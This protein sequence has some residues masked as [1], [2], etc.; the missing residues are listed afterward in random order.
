MT[1]VGPSTRLFFL[2]GAL[3]AW[4]A[5]S[6]AQS[7]IAGQVRD[8]TGAVLPGVTVEAASPALI[9]GRRGVATDGQGRYS[10]VDVR[11]G[12]YTVTFTLAGFGTVIRQGI[13]LPSNFTATVDATLNVGALEESVTVTGDAPLV[14]VQQTTRTQVLNRE[15]LDNL[16]TSR[17]T[18]TQAMLLAGVQMTGTDVGGSRA[19][20][21]LLLE[22]HGASS[23]HSTYNIDGMQV[24]TM[25]SD[26]REQNYYQDQSNQEVSIQTSGGNA[27][28]AKGGVFLNMIPKDGGNE[29]HGTSVHRRV[30][31]V[32]DG[33]QLLGGAAGAG[34][35][36]DRQHHADL[37]LRRDTGRADSPRPPVVPRLGA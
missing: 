12:T 2:A 13:E 9:E 16:V 15:A 37:R 29:F 24:D 17:N 6:S 30:E 23:L 20:S 36:R 35:P 21:D 19:A 11:P 10:I 22:S 8:N 3:L 34:A 26:G 27:E 31:W 7:A 14:D 25:L 4:P 18:W 33:R 5:A 28:V 1:C 32:L